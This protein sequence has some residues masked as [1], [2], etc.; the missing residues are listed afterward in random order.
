MVLATT[1]LAVFV[2][3]E[4]GH[5][6]YEGAEDFAIR[7]SDEAIGI[8]TNLMNAP[9]SVAPTLKSVIGEISVRAM[10]AMERD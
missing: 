6:M 8:Q 3:R 10:I 5:F 7:A 4:V 1:G 9:S 2:L